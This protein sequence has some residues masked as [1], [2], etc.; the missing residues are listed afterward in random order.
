MEITV[1]I[2][3]LQLQRILEAIGWKIV[4]LERDENRL[5]VTIEKQIQELKS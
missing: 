2:E 3:I 1:N 5:I 4:R